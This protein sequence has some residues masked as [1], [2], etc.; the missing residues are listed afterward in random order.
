VFLEE[1]PTGLRIRVRVQPKASRE[2]VVG[3]YGD[4]LKISLTA[5]AS[6]GQ[7][8]RALVRFLS[9]R[10]DVSPSAI[11]IVHGVSSRT[12][13]LEIIGVSCEK[14]AALGLG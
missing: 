4:S 6:D 12:K 13:V 1:T 8:N 5:P 11:H 9:N 10:L 3:L 7:A 2:T 14:L